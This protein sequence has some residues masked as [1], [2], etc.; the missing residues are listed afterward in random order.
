MFKNIFKKKEQ[1][2]PEKYKRILEFHKEAFKK[3]GWE[4]LKWTYKEDF[5]D[6][7]TSN[8]E[9][10]LDIRGF[11]LDSGSYYYYYFDRG[12]GEGWSDVDGCSPPDIY[13]K[14]EGNKLKFQYNQ[15]SG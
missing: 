2:L 5:K 8:P 14:N 13:V 9:P 15:I 1:T 7:A 10:V 12:Y 4:G 6:Y 11:S 3:A